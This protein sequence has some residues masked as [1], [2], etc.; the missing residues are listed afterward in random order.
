MAAC[1]RCAYSGATVV[2]LTIT[3]YAAGGTRDHVSGSASSPV[4]MS[5]W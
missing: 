3:P 5:I 4:P 1:N 2:L